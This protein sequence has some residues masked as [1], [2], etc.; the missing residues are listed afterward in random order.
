[1]RN[2]IVSKM[3]TAGIPVLLAVLLVN[4]IMTNKKPGFVI[5]QK[6]VNVWIVSVLC[7]VNRHC[8]Y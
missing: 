3:M 5:L 2:T 8:H 6:A 1:M 4:G 7:K